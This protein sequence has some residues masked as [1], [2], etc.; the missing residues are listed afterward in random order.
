MNRYTNTP[1]S[2]LIIVT[3]SA[4]AVATYGWAMASET[5]DVDITG[6]AGDLLKN[7][8]AF[9]SIVDAV[10]EEKTGLI[11]GFSIKKTK[12]QT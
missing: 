9:L 10:E 3:V 5:V 12:G 4:I 1:R 8:E 2:I 11:P 7:V 6:V